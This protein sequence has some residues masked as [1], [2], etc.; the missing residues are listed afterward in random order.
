MT[1][2]MSPV[3]PHEAVLFDKDGTLFD[4]ASTWNGWSRNM[5]ETLSAGEA[6]ILPRLA[7]A[8]RFDLTQDR[9]FEDSIA[10]AG[11]NQEIAAALG[12]HLPGWSQNELAQHLAVTAAE[13]ELAQA[14]PLIPFLARL[15]QAGLRLGVMTND[16]A[17]SAQR[18]LTRAGVIDQFEQVIGADSGHGAKP[19]P[20]PLLAFCRLCG[21][22]PERT[23]MVG[24]SLH[25]LVAG[26]AAGMKTVGV[27]TGLASAE[28]LAPK[29]D[30]VLENI[31][32]IPEWLGL[33]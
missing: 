7:A 14:V 5:L 3:T 4:F 22:A 33:I 1:N 27:L 10:I 11:T 25:D 28:E 16:S 8:I 15:R 19:D 26:R 23:I 12:P 6:E 29:A 9:F 2:E 32:E 30:I 17:H 20:D 13:A 18:H 21:V 31:G 24:D